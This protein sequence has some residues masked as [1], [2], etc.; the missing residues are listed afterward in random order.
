[1]KSAVPRLLAVGYSLNLSTEWIRSWSTR[2]TRYNSRNSLIGLLSLPSHKSQ[3]MILVRTEESR[4]RAATARGNRLALKERRISPE[5]R[6]SPNILPQINNALNGTIGTLFCHNWSRTE[7]AIPFRARRKVVSVSLPD[8]QRAHQRSEKDDGQLV[9]FVHLLFFFFPKHNAQ[10]V[11]S[12]EDAH[13][14][15]EADASAKVS[16]PRGRDRGN[17]YSNTMESTA[18][19]KPTTGK[20]P[21]LSL[22]CCTTWTSARN[23]TNRYTVTAAR[24]SRARSLIW[25]S[26]AAVWA[27]SPPLTTHS[28][29]RTDEFLSPLSVCRVVDGGRL[30]SV[31]RYSWVG[32]SCSNIPHYRLWEPRPTSPGRPIAERPYFRSC[33]VRPIWR[34]STRPAVLPIAVWIARRRIVRDAPWP[35]PLRRRTWRWSKA[36]YAHAPW[37]ARAR[38][39]PRSGT[40][41]RNSTRD[42]RLHD[43]TAPCRAASHRTAPRRAAPHRVAPRRTA[44]RRAVPNQAGPRRRPHRDTALPLLSYVMLSS[45]TRLITG[46]FVRACVRPVFSREWSLE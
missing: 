31:L 6:T 12:R 45:T 39:S 20:E 21:R 38:S 26:G 10:S 35:F 33:V 7:N 16:T 40:G 17:C 13:S 23:N 46:I 14:M 29:S 19:A 27:A 37:P 22:A 28:A 2:S 36:W 25:S 18:N 43:V 11:Y 4:W 32:G 9:N 24:R 42:A 44:P 5:R 34:A 1:M 15:H 8:L 30:A 3:E 41:L